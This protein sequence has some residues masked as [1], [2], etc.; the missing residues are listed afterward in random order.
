MLSTTGLCREEGTQRKQATKENEK[1]NIFT[2]RK[3]ALVRSNLDM[4][5]S[6]LSSFRWCFLSRKCKITQKNFGNKI[7]SERLKHFEGSKF[8]FL[9]SLSSKRSM[10][11]FL[12]F[13]PVT[14]LGMTAKAPSV[15][16]RDRGR[17]EVDWSS[18][19]AQLALRS[20]DVSCFCPT[21]KL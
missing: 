3:L 16:K 14:G 4:P 17:S 12:A 21:L 8:T 20:S 19:V 5:L 6:L 9:M 11:P 18:A 15:G 13:G 2:D 1:K 7:I 10:D